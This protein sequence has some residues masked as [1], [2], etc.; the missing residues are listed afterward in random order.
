[1]GRGASALLEMVIV[2]VLLGLAMALTRQPHT[3]NYWEEGA[4]DARS[5]ADPRQL[6]WEKRTW[7][8]MTVY[9]SSWNWPVV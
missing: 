1:M 7:S 3:P 9:R 5:R 8:G 6:M 4:A 2:L